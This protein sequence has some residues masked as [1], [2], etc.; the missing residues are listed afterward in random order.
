MTERLSKRR[1]RA[2]AVSWLARL[3]GDAS[4]L[5]REEFDRWCA[6]DVKH[7]KVVAELQ[8]AWTA[9]DLPTN[10]DYTVRVRV[11]LQDRI[12]RRARWRAA[13]ATLC[14]LI[15]FVGIQQWMLHRAPQKSPLA[16]SVRFM[17]TTW[18]TLPDGSEAELS[19]EAR[20]D[21]EF[22]GG[23]RRVVLRSGDA[24]FHVLKDET[25]PFVVVADRVQVRAVG[26]SFA[27]GVSQMGVQV[28]VTAGTVSVGDNGEQPA[29]SPVEA[30]PTAMLLEVGQALVVSADATVSKVPIMLN[31][32]E[33]A[34]RLAWRVPRLEFTDTPLREALARFNQR[35]EVRLEVADGSSENLRISGLFRADNSEGFVELLER[36]FPLVAERTEGEIRLRSKIQR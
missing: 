22:S 27:V 7:A 36:T 16:S 34:R 18:I 11:A 31:E 30:G 2:V 4:L 9:L 21:T 33:L 14:L 10:G 35:N 24:H 19:P 15:A 28:V 32:P 1:I 12:A 6:A 8:R 5:D 29:L 20:I 25:R 13:A 3:D 23:V 17:E 26:T